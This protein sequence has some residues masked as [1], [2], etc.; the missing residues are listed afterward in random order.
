MVS[1]YD[2]SKR[3]SHRE[4][5]SQ[6]PE[7]SL[8]P[9]DIDSITVVKVLTL[10]NSFNTPKEMKN[11]ITMRAGERVLSIQLARRIL[12]KREELGRF[13][14]LKQVAVVPGI[15]INK[16]NAIIYALGESI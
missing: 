4:K 10:L 3:H 14:D 11:A 5:N 15:G 9:R 2:T 16:F 6:I 12:N 8:R 13:E 7:T 1:R